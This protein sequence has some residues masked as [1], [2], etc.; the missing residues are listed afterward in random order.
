METVT[1]AGKDTRIN[2]RL[3]SAELEEVRE[4]AK[5]TG[6]SVS[7]YGRR[8]LLGHA[9]VSQADA[10]AI[11]ELRRLGGLLKHINLETDFQ[12][13]QEVAET[14][15]ELRHAIQRLGA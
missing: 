7:A 13:S 10:E 3:T 11:R 12:L 6:L 14:F 9:V 5:L 1:P 8:R 2:I 15:A 4:A